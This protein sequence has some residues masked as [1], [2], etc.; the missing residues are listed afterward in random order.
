MR[1][2]FLSFSPKY[3]DVLQSG[4]KIYEYRK[5][6]CDEAVRAYIYLG[7]PVRKVVGI[8]WLGER[9]SLEYWERVYF[10]NKDVLRRIKNYSTRNKYVM[11]ILKYQQIEPIDIN[12]IK[13]NFPE[14]YIPLSFRNLDEGSILLNFIEDNTVYKDK[15]IIHDFENVSEDRI[16]EM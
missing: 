8:A 12:C 10:E 7:K 15:P 3:Y 6:F 1:T 2:I 4:A 14:F 9:I 16:C 11:P 13:E 5:R